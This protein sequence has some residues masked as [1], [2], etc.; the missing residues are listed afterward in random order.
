MSSSSLSRGVPSK[1][2]AQGKVQITN[3]KV[4]LSKVTSKCGSKDNIKHKPGGGDLKI[5]SHKMNFKDKAQSK[6]GSL[7]NVG[8][9]PGGGSVKAE[10][11]P[12]SEG[13]G[14]VESAPEACSEAGAAGASAHHNGINV[15]GETGDTGSQALDA[16]IPETN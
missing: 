15:T 6:V 12:E 14:P 10:G 11:D 5:E 13:P 3:K 16:L 4:D 2:P 7:E 8:H 9:T 1:D